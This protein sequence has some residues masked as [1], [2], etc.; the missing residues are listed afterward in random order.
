MPPAYRADGTWWRRDPRAGR[1]AARRE[2]LALLEAI[3]V[4]DEAAAADL[5]LAHV[6]GFEGAI[7]ALL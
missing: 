7:R 3:I 6:A 5:T 1:P 2:H 4:G